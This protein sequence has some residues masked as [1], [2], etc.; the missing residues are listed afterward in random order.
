M[1]RT[2]PFGN[3]L[4]RK[5]HYKAGRYYAVIRNKWYSLD[6]NYGEAMKNAELLIG[7]LDLKSHTRKNI[8]KF[9]ENL[10]VRAKQNA[11]QD[12]PGRRKKDFTI[13]RSDV[14]KMAND[15]D[16]RCEVT[17][18]P[19]SLEQDES[20]GRRPLA[21]SIDRIDNGKGY[22]DGNV[23]LVCVITNTALNVWGEQYLNTISRNMVTNFR[24]S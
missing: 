20:T 17:G 12:G 24:S 1:P 9:L 4:P 5:V 21:P 15:C 14:I 6:K 11:K 10:W 16:Y 18:T 19:F 3:E 8:D 13:T 7:N 23:R 22:I 2:D